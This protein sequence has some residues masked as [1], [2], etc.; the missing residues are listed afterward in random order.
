MHYN[1]ETIIQQHIQNCLNSF[2]H[3]VDTDLISHL[4]EALRFRFSGTRPEEIKNIYLKDYEIPQIVLFDILANRFPMVLNGQKAVLHALLQQSAGAKHIQLLDLGIGRGLQVGR[5]LQ[6]LAENP[7]IESVRVVG[8][9]IMKDALDFT[10]SQFKSLK[11]NLP[12]LFEFYPIH[13]SFEELDWKE[14]DQLLDAPHDFRMVNASLA[15][16]HIQQES[17]RLKIFEQVA[18]LKPDLLTLIEP[19]AD[20]F[21][22]DFNKRLLNSYEHFSA[23]FAFINT[24]SL[25]LA[26]KKSLKQFFSHEFYDNI[27]LPDSHR[28]EKHQRAERWLE[29]AAEK[30]FKPLEKA[31]DDLKFDF[32]G[33]EI[34]IS[35]IPYLNFSFPPS[36]ILAIMALHCNN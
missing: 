23:L 26:E 10:T 15:L 16:H 3:A 27:A 6:A 9:E 35:N 32:P 2:S 24:Q 22:D 14:V 12:F 28:F 4:E 21:T 5:M 34:T 1:L 33:A 11:E 25:T 36:D 18:L 13:S 29:L 30:G 8:I 7:A 19:N 31:F 20:N 17:E